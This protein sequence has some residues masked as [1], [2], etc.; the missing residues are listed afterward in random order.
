MGHCVAHGSVSE[1]F[2]AVFFSLKYWW[3]SGYSLFLV[4]GI[5]V[6]QGRL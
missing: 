3:Q 5:P 2:A 4:F 1:G 6:A